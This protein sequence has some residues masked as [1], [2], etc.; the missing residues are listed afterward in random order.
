MSG[1]DNRQKNTSFLRY[2]FH[3]DHVGVTLLAFLLIQLLALIAFN[4]KPL[5]PI[6]RS[7]ENFRLTD[8]FYEI[9]NSGAERDTSDLVT[10]VDM[11]GIYERGR[12]AEIIDEVQRYEPSVLGVDIVFDDV[13]NDLAGNERLIETVCNAD[14]STVWAYILQDW[15]S[16]EGRYEH[17]F[18]SFFT[19]E[20]EVDREGF[21]NAQRDTNGGTVR[22]MGLYRNVGGRREYSL[23]AQIALAVTNDSS[24]VSLR[25]DCDI[26]YTA[27]HYPV[28]SA[29][30]IAAHP[31]LI[32]SRI[33]LLGGINDQ[34]DQLFTPLGKLPGVLVHAYAVQTLVQRRMPKEVPFWL[35]TM[36]IF[37]IVWLVEVIQV[38]VTRRL[39]SAPSLSLKNYMGSSFMASNLISLLALLLLVGV[40]FLFFLHWNIYF[41]TTW[42]IMGIVLLGK[43]RML[44]ELF[45]RLLEARLHWPLLRRSLFFKTK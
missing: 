27:M 41:N 21:I 10:I 9:S 40:S 26:R 31:E 17:S 14:S 18:H 12:L 32:R 33:V 19:E 25:P 29:D 36:A 42:A 28:V 34:R 6:A 3:V 16:D 11:S 7:I 24:F 1:I 39:T 43:S 30:S 23:A 8:I 5:N 35:L 2:V 22:T 38:W 37:G 20:V 45:V 44:Y 13:R 4:V 15:N